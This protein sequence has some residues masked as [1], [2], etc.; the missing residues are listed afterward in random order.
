MFLQKDQ[1]PQANKHLRQRISLIQ[2]MLDVLRK[3]LHLQTRLDKIK[4]EEMVREIASRYN[5][6]VEMLVAV[7]WAE[8]G[9]NPKAINRNTGGTTDFG[10]CQ[11]NDYWYKDQ[12]SPTRALNDPAFAVQVMCEA[13]ERGRQWDWI[14]YRNK[15]YL[16]FLHV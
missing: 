6:N 13:W 4:T 5:V 10:L 9:M 15:S 14:A 2:Q 7:I 11:F 12:I 8:S 16:K 3:I 1:K